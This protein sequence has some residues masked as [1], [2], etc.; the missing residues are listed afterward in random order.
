MSCCFSRA[1]VTYIYELSKLTDHD[2]ATQWFAFQLLVHQD[3]GEGVASF[4]E[5]LHL[6]LIKIL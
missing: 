5:L 4:L 3:V 1:A 2:C 6:P